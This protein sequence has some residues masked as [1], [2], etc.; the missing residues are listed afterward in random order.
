MKA[1]ILIISLLI[2][3]FANAFQ[4]EPMV[5]K[6]AST[7]AFAQAEYRVENT[8][9]EPLAVEAIVVARSVELNTE[10][11]L[12]PAERDFIVM[13]PQATIAPGEFQLFRIRY[14]G[15]SSPIKQSTSYRIVFKQLPLQHDAEGSGVDL[16]FNFST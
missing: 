14:L 8:G 6:L 2:S 11:T 1:L 7:G 13:P 5:H 16:L 3:T 9:S 15:D 12:T 4:V 10:E